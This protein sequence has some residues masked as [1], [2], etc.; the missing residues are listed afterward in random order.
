MEPKV[1]KER[2]KMYPTRCLVCQKE[3]ENFD[4]LMKADDKNGMHPCIQGGHV[5]IFCGYGSK[6]DHLHDGGLD[7]EIKRQAIICDN[8]LDRFEK[9]QS[10]MRKIEIVERIKVEWRTVD[11]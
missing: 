1:L 4:D 8:C 5:S 6:F 7:R 3:V 2:F 9:N 10:V 11:N